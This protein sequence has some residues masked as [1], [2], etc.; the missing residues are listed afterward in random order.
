[1]MPVAVIWDNDEQS[2]IRFDFKH[3][4]T[5]DDF[6]SA[7][8]LAFRMIEATGHQVDVI[9]DFNNSRVM[10]EGMTLHM[11]NVLSA[12]PAHLRFI[13]VVTNNPVIDTN[14]AVLSR[15]HK[16]LGERLLT[17][18]SVDAARTAL[19]HP[20]TLQRSVSPAHFGKV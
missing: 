6:N 9:F 10:P 13:L 7:C 8:R 1:M 19:L 3:G 11:R 17:V 16:T 12:A 2:V 14:F 5:W 4:W 15:V 20:Y 18:P